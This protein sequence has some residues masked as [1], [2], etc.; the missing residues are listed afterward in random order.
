MLP[1]YHS[2]W[3]QVC[4]F[5]T[6]MFGG[7]YFLSNVLLATVYS[8]FRNRLENDAMQMIREQEIYLSEYIDILADDNEDEYLNDKVMV[9]LKPRQVQTFFEEIFKLMPSKRRYDY[10]T[11]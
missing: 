9:Y 3:W 10:D 6:Y 1:A 2:N 5:I 4:L 7:L 11:L 8:R